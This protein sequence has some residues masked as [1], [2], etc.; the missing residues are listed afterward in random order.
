[1]VIHPFVIRTRSERILIK[2]MNA[3]QGLS[4]EPLVGLSQAAVRKWIENWYPNRV[5][6]DV[7]RDLTERLE[8]ISE[9]LRLGASASHRGAL[10]DPPPTAHDVREELANIRDIVTPFL[11]H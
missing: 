10:A 4:P 5:P 2:G 3:L 6:P 11:K 9:R 1:M 7:Q 8:T